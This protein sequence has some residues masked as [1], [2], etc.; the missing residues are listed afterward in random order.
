[1]RREGFADL[2]PAAGEPQLQGVLGAVRH[3][4]SNRGVFRLLLGAMLVQMAIFVVVTFT[5]PI[6]SDRFGQSLEDLLWLLVIIHV[7]S[8]P[9]TLLWS[10]LLTGAARPLVTVLLLASWAA[11]LL[12]LA[13]GSGPWM[14]VITVTVIGCCLGATF[15][16]LRGFLAESIG[17]SDPVA[18]F[19]LATAAGRIAAGLGPALFSLIMLA[20]GEQMALLFMLL[21]LACG[22]GLILTTLRR[23]PPAAAKPDP[24]G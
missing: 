5:T 8:V 24:A 22:G 17:H 21:V 7:V 13:F 9:S 18:F 6:L 12:L 14:P 11:V 16:G 15:S 2:K 10:H 23:E 3:W 20:A 19:A 1:M 4:R